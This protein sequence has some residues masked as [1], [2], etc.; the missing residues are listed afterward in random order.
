MRIFVIALCVAI[1]VPVSIYSQNENGKGKKNAFMNPY[2][3][4]QPPK[5]ESQPEKDV[6]EQLNERT[7]TKIVPTS[8]QADAQDH[9][10]KSD[11]DAGQSESQV[12]SP[13][14][15]TTEGQFFFTE[16]V[17]YDSLYPE[18]NDGTMNEDGFEDQEKVVDVF[19]GALPSDFEFDQEQIDY[20]FQPG[21]GFDDEPTTENYDFPVAQEKSASEEENTT[22]SPSERSSLSSASSFESSSEGSETKRANEF[23]DAEF[24]RRFM[25]I[26]ARSSSDYESSG[27]SSAD[28][29]TETELSPKARKE[30]VSSLK[31][32]SSDDWF[33]HGST[34]ESTTHPNTNYESSR[35]DGKHSE[36]VNSEEATANEEIK[37]KTSEIEDGGHEDTITG[38]NSQHSDDE[39]SASTEFEDKTDTSDHRLG[40]P[41]EVSLEPFD[42]VPPPYAEDV[43]STTEPM[44]LATENPYDI[45]EPIANNFDKV[46]FIPESNEY[47]LSSSITTPS[48]LLTTTAVPI[49]QMDAMKTSDNEN[50]DQTDEYRK[51]GRDNEIPHRD[52]PEKVQRLSLAGFLKT[53]FSFMPMV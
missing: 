19:P 11:I 33:T 8:E 37:S 50:D 40:W 1:S 43:Y 16:F 27:K 12:V 38:D 20:S 39:A 45:A 6:K 15:S 7:K 23:W 21:F 46:V 42:F 18:V 13:F 30:S 48:T 17:P 34:S 51:D 41:L 52:Q 53:I 47:H 31:E 14:D 25:W 35:T 32:S 22:E 9:Q 5:T 4:F 26:M 36:V 24:L 28:A 44:T 10:P 49:T 2:K 3:K 29:I